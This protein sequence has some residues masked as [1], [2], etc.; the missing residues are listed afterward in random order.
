VIAAGLDEAER[1]H[2]QRCES[3]TE[4]AAFLSAH[5]KVEAAMHPSLADHP[6]A[7]VIAEHY[8]R[9]GSLISLRVEG[10]DERA[11]RHFCDVL[12]T[13]LVVRYALSF[14]GLTTKVN[15]HKSVSEYFTPPDR[16]ARGGLDRLVRL[17]VGTEDPRDLKA[18][19]NWSLHH[20][21]SVDQEALDRW[22]QERRRDLQLDR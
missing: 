12:A 16:L 6:D 19:L 14:D 18:C 1:A 20:A 15:H 4:I 13:T 11:T 22:R 9:P 3:A 21:P 7:A 8:A 5:P 10:A 17:A 2:A